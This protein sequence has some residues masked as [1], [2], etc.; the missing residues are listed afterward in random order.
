MRLRRLTR[1]RGKGTSTGGAAI[2]EYAF[3]LAFFAVPAVVATGTLG[4]KL[5]SSYV[6]TRNN[7][8]HQGP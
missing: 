1:A 7:L 8:L 6:E 3:L 4:V 5:I 2:V